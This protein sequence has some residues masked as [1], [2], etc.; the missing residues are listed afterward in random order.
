MH[1][2]EQHVDQRKVRLRGSSAAT[3]RECEV[4]AQCNLTHL[5]ELLIDMIIGIALVVDELHKGQRLVYRYP[6]S[7][8]SSVL[9]STAGLLKFHQDYQSLRY[10]N[11]YRR[12]RKYGSTVAQKS[13]VSFTFDYLIFENAAQTILRNFFALRP[14]YLTR[15]WS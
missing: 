7:V 3:S 2:L 9:N 4:F 13:A 11:M 8:P 1:N 15:F 5:G 10:S 14:P 6:E 12:I